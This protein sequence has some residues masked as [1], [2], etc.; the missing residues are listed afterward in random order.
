[1]QDLVTLALE[2]GLNHKKENWVRG[3]E[4][5][6]SVVNDRGGWCAN[7]VSNLARK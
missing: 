6:S 4:I 3:S 1:M 5:V 2:T 7:Q